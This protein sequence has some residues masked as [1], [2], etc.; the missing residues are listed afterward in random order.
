[1]SEADPLGLRPTVLRVDLDA[2]SLNVSALRTAG[3][4]R[5]LLAVVKANGYGCGAG[6]VARAALRGGASW[7]GVALVEEGVQLRDRGIGAPVLMLGPV[8]PQQAGALLRF[9]LTP[10]VYSI[11]FLRAVEEAAELAGR[12]VE[13][14]LKL[15]SGMGRVGFRR[16]E[17]PRLLGAL[18]ASP[19]VSVTGVFSNLASADD[20]GSGQTAGQVRAFQDMVETLRRDGIEPAWIHLANSS[21]LLAHP[22]THLTLCRPGLTL[23]GLRP[24]HDLPDPGLR[25]VLSFSTQVAQ[26]KQVPPGTPVGYGA[27]YV[28]SGPKRL[29]ILPVGYGDGLPRALGNVGHVLV[30]GAACPLVGRV[31]MDLVAADLD[32]APGATEGSPVC[33]WGRDGSLE[34]GPWDWARWSGTIPYEVMT[35]ISCRVARRYA[36]QGREWTE[37]LLNSGGISARGT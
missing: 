1:M 32:P 20:L 9:D 22:E 24:S 19:R 30:G 31:S 6:P 26:I 35:G 15:D 36:E 11:S 21:G 27:T 17:I 2:L 16:E 8:P 34:A 14:H 12:S 23:F 4:D 29:G 13:V 25:P 3:G 33:L 7:L 37:L 5:P 18:R 28:T 10:A